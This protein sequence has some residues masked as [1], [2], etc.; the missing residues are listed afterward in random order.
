MSALLHSL[1]APF[2]LHGRN[3]DVLDCIANLSNDEVFTPPQFANRMLDTLAEAWAA[4]HGG[5]S[6]WENAEVRFLDPC[7]KSGVFLR[8]ITR[9]LVQ[10]LAGQIPDLQERVNH[11]LRRQV[12]GIG[13]TRL[14]AL[15]AR[16]S[17]YCSKRANGR[18]SIVQGFEGEAGHIWFERT[19][20]DWERGKCRYCGASQAALDRGVELE[21]H[22][23][24]FIHTDDIK[25]RMHELFEEEMQFDVIIGNPPYQLS[26]GGH[27]VSAAPIYQKFVEQAKALDPRYLTMVIPSRWFTGGKGLD[28]FREA[29]LTDDRVRVINDYL[30]ASDVFPGVGLKGGVCYFLWERDNPGLCEVATH[31]KD[32]PVSTAIRPLL[33]PGADVFVRFNEGLSIL[34]KVMALECGTTETLALPR[35]KRFDELVSSLRPFGLRTFFKG[36]SKRRVG[37]LAIYQNGGVGYIAPADVPT[38][39]ELIDHW[40]IY[41]GRA[42]PGTGNRDT[43]PHRILSTPFIGE[44]GSI[45]SETY[46]CI[47]PFASQSEAE[48]A[49]SYLACRLTRLLILLHKP[50]Q[51]TTRRVYTFVPIQDWSRRWSDADLY[52]KYGISDSEIEFIEKIV[53]PMDLSANLFGEVSVDEDADE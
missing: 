43:Y 41:I 16:R 35:E 29:M 13:I 32:W 53:R 31:F 8:E 44:P 45:C 33:E 51:D 50:S 17:V 5:A 11:I 25:V 24:A 28:E 15:L 52:S 49:L 34:R 12:F 23:Y 10:G 47:G 6:I 4:A 3:P 37:D 46:L 40:K 26:D 18:H 9:R 22:A 39:H 7:T 38:G 1:Q 48:S 19:E 36:N 14:T 30:T 27:G 20:H 2:A 21:S 42:A